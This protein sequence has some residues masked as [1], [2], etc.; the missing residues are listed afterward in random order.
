MG[1]PDALFATDSSAVA[2]IPAEIKCRCYPSYTT[3]IPYQTKHDIPV[4]HIIQVECYLE[5]VNA[6]FAFLYN[7]T[8]NCGATN[9]VIRRDPTFFMDFVQPLLLEFHSLGP[10]K[11][12]R[13]VDRRSKARV[14]AKLLDMVEKNVDKVERSDCNRPQPTLKYAHKHLAQPVVHCL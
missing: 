4:K 9:Y 12:K 7:W 3:A 8:A 13:R 10:E 5:L 6:P 14:M 2:P 11:M 1:E